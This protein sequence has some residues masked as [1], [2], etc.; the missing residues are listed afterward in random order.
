MK[1]KE[2]L[3]ELIHSLT[4]SEKRYF[5]VFASMHGANNNY[6]QLFDAIHKQKEYDEEAL[7][8]RFK[9]KDFVRQF[10]VAKNYLLN[11]ILKS[12]RNHHHK[13]KVSIEIND[14][15]S[16]VELLYWKGLYKLSFKRLQ[17]AKK[18]AEKYDLILYLMQ[19]NYWQDKLQLY[20][21]V[22]LSDMVDIEELKDLSSDVVVLMKLE[23]MSK[24]L[25]SYTR[26][27]MKGTQE[28][29]ETVTRL[30]ANPVLSEDNEKKI[31]NFNILNKIYTIKSIGYSLINDADKEFEYKKKVIDLLEANPHQIEENP[32]RY[33]SAL[34]NMLI[35]YYVRRHGEHPEDI[36]TL[37][38]KLNKINLK[39]PHA[40]HTVEHNKF[41]FNLMYHLA[42]DDFDSI[43]LLVEEAEQWYPELMEKMPKHTRMIFEY[44][45]S[46]V[47]FALGD[48]KKALRWGNSML[49]YFDKKSK[50]FRHDL[51]VS[52]LIIMY[53]I[54][55]ELGYL[56]LA[57]KNMAQIEE[58]ARYN[59]YDVFEKE[60][61]QQI[62]LFQSGKKEDEQQ[63][64]G[65]LKKLVQNNPNR[66][67]NI[68]EDIFVQYLKKIEQ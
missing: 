43:R 58:I 21:Q 49:R 22:K 16:E 12:L 67:S 14:L 9:D 7:K 13:A 28:A 15:L 17:Q 64:V 31:T 34:N 23:R 54:Y 53:L 11:L 45:M 25:M 44:N 10:S 3:F 57:K 18:I 32:I 47:Y 61:I 8:K 37:L 26:K 39:F 48:N 66:L 52:E 62:K 50:S 42:N 29:I 46:L 2:L 68:D 38:N 55:I 40:R 36:K 56:E 33:T 65:Y 35:Y 4:K 60:I 41:S 63:A 19:I 5:K 51:V 24:E 27:T 6:V 1:S 20:I 59:K 30:F